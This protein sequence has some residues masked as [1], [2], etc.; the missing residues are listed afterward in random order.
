MCVWGGGEGRRRMTMCVW[1]G[2]GQGDGEW[3]CVYMCGEE[4]GNGGVCVCVG[5]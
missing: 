3:R 5:G 4:K 1:G 2:G